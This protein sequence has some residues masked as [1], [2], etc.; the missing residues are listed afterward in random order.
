MSTLG[1]DYRGHLLGDIASEAGRFDIVPNAGAGMGS[2][3]ICARTARF[4]QPHHRTIA[5]ESISRRAR[6]PGTAP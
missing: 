4:P 6:R 2:P 3:G 1:S 5:A